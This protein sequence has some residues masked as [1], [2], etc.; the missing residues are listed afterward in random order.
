[1]TNMKGKTNPYTYT[2]W[3]RATPDAIILAIPPGRA[4]KD[5]RSIAEEG[6]RG[7]VGESPV[8][9]PPLSRYA[10]IPTKNS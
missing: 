2:R 5:I 3:L 6:D 9:S 7:E 8:L 1:M 4:H 10:W